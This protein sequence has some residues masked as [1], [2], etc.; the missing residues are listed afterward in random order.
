LR[1]VVRTHFTQAAQ[2]ATS[3]PAYAAGLRAAIATVA[4]I[5]AGQVFG[6]QDVMWMGLAGFNVALSD[7]GGTIRTRMTSML[8][9]ALFG[10]LAAVAGAF[11][12]RY[13]WMSIAM[14]ALWAL[15]AG[16]AR[17]WGA[18][19]T[20]TG[21]I[22][23]VTFIVSLE[24]PAATA[25]AAFE[26]GSAILAGSAFAITL[27]LLVWPVRIY[28][29][30]RHAVA[31][32]YRAIAAFAISGD[33]SAMSIARREIDNARMSLAALR[34]GLNGETPRGERLLVLVESGD[35]LLTSLERTGPQPQVAPILETIARTVESERNDKPGD[36]ATRQPGG[37]LEHQLQVAQMA[38]AELND[39]RLRHRDSKP[40]W[41]QIY[42]DPIVKN[43]NWR[44]V[45]LRHALRVAVAAAAAEALATQLHIPRRYWV[46][47]TVIIILQPHT[48]STVQKGLQRLVG[49]ILGGVV[50]AV[51]LGLVHSPVQMI[52]VVFIGAA[53]TV[54][55][56]PVNYGLYSLFLTPTFILLAEV[57][58]ID[59][60]LVW[61]RVN[62]TILGAAIA[63]V[64]AW[65]LWPASERGRVRDDL[66][67]ALRELA[68]YTRCVGECDEV[69]AAESRRAFIVAL[70]NG[71][72]S[73]Q[74]LL[75][76]R[77]GGDTESLMAIL[78][79]ARRY[80]IALSALVAASSDRLRLGPLT[81]YAAA[82]LTDIA[83]SLDGLRV[84]A[85]FSD[86][87]EARTVAGADRLLDALIALHHAAGRL[88]L[89]R[90]DFR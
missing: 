66:A 3:Q 62:N 68:D 37:D 1:A 51:L 63:Y 33:E 8:A 28:R 46:T 84:P 88:A 67:A 4:P 78:V 89:L 70:E 22:S 60:H 34:R 87:A 38:A 73:L 44:S 53:L 74:R 65:V 54:A 47:L 48:S 35:R 29:P 14:V 52:V 76:D 6:W 36:P 59:R 58:A 15:A 12:G 83:A 25:A 80:A 10:A 75:T 43:L 81:R 55:L 18:I 17:T 72:A 61:L 56:L 31:R 49:T 57:S 26:R 85:E 23:F 30:V 82:S 32:A 19:A 11:A 40:T 79:Y 7:K 64:A 90:G 71:E 13:A 21:I 41:M 16:M 20:T 5:I 77:E 24:A 2:V 42:A 45:V 9:P 86:D 27:A 39:D 50:A 69:Q